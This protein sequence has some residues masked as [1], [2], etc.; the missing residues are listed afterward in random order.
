[1]S[2]LGNYAFKFNKRPQLF[3]AVSHMYASMSSGSSLSLEQLLISCVL[4]V[5]V[6]EDIYAR[7]WQKK[8]K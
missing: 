5:L 2:G 4:H 7:F 8:E 1:M 3:C 6:L